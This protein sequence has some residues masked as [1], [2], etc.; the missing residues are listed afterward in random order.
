LGLNRAPAHRLSWLPL[1]PD[2]CSLP[3]RLVSERGSSR[4][5]SWR[6]KTRQ[7]Y[8]AFCPPAPL[9]LSPTT[10][11]RARASLRA[12]VSRRRLG[13]RRAT[14]RRTDRRT[15]RSSVSCRPSRCRRRLGLTRAR[16]APARQRLRRRHP[17]YP[18]AGTS[19]EHPVLRHEGKPGEGGVAFD[20]PDARAR[21]RAFTQSGEAGARR[22]KAEKLSALHKLTSGKRPAR[23]ALRQVRPCGS[24]TNH[25]HRTRPGRYHAFFFFRSWTR[26]TRATEPE[27]EIIS[28]STWDLSRRTAT[29]TTDTVS[30]LRREQHVS[31]DVI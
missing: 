10:P 23:A 26:Q 11:A 28:R 20:S 4:R 27:S 7:K 18:S 6:A 2:H 24:G 3:V 5:I 14:Q 9:W 29:I 22:G 1:L 12:A 16:G 15:R 8:A 17:F 21:G 13:R 30:R 31:V 19:P 25:V